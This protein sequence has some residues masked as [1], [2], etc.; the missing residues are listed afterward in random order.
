MIFARSDFV[1]VCKIRRCHCG[2]IGGTGGGFGGKGS[3]GGFGAGGFGLGGFGV[4]GMASPVVRSIFNHTGPGMCSGKRSGSVDDF[5][6]LS[7]ARRIIC[8]PAAPGLLFL[9]PLRPYLPAGF[10]TELTDGFLATRQLC[11]ESS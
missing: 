8:N 7:V 10:P 2:R 11:Y 4:L 5:G 1:N 9:A 3:G 6:P